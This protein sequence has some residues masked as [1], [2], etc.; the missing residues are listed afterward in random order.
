MN[1]HSSNFHIMG[2]HDLVLMTKSTTYLN[3][4]DKQLKYQTTNSLKN[5]EC[6]FVQVVI[7][8]YLPVMSI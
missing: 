2:N 5:S 4:F 6:V 7:T 8:S 1:T 3:I